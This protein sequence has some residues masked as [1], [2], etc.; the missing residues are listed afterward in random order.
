[1]DTVKCSKFRVSNDRLITTEVVNLYSL[2]S[3]G[4]IEEIIFSKMSL[5]FAKVIQYYKN[6]KHHNQCF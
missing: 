5:S 2:I 6:V 1:M 3:L 4:K